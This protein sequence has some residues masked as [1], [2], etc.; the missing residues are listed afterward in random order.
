MRV[1]FS[2]PCSLRVMEHP[3]QG[4][5]VCISSH[6]HGQTAH[7]TFVSHS[8]TSCL[9][10]SLPVDSSTIRKRKT[11]KHKEEKDR[12]KTRRERE[13]GNQQAKGRLKGKKGKPARQQVKKSGKPGQE[14]LLFSVLLFFLFFCL[15]PRPFGQPTRTTTKA[16]T[17][18]LSHLL[19]QLFPFSFSCVGLVVVVLFSSALSTRLSSCPCSCLSSVSCFSFFFLSSSHA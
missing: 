4:A 9:T 1:P 3:L 5:G 10:M 15:V 13:T 12:S 6:A 8:C 18:C 14:T 19:Y 17:S 2:E 7:T 16:M 11:R